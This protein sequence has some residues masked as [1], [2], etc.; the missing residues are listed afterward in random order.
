MYQRENIHLRKFTMFLKHSTV[1]SQSSAKYVRCAVPRVLHVPCCV[2]PALVP[3]TMPL[4]DFQ[5]C[6]E[7]N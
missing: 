6:V 7:R 5:L 3:V 2:Y 4:S 1:S